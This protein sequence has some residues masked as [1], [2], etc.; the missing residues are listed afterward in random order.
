MPAALAALALAAA[1]CTAEPPGGDGGSFPPKG[2]SKYASLARCT[3]KAKCPGP[4]CAANMTGAPDGKAVDMAACATADLTWTAGH[5][6][7]ETSG[8]DIALHMGKISGITRVEASTDGATYTVVGF[9]GGTPAG[10]PASCVSSVSGTTAQIHLDRCN[11]ITNVIHLRISRD[12]SVKGA[13]SIDAAEAL[14]F[15]PSF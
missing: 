11:A 13:I 9:I 2:Q 14:N 8:P 6:R 12:T 3:P 4:N 15:S 10:T 5:V 7:S 1:A